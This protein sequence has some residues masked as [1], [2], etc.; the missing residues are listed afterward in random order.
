MIKKGYNSTGGYSLI[1]NRNLKSR[2]IHGRIL[3]YIV[4]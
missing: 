2:I 4:L 3:L 1:N